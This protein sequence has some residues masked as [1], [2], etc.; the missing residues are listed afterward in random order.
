MAHTETEQTGSSAPEDPTSAVRRK[1]RVRKCAIIAAVLAGGLLVG[2]Y[3]VDTYLW[4]RAERVK[5]YE[6]GP[7]AKPERCL[8][9]WNDN[10]SNFLLFRPDPSLSWSLRPGARVRL[11]YLTQDGRRIPFDVVVNNCGMR[12]RA[13]SVRKS[14]GTLRVFC[15]GDSRTF[16]LGVQ[17]DETY[18]AR[19]GALASEELPGRRAESFNAGVP[20]YT[21][22]QGLLRIRQLLRFR[23]DV[24]T[25]C[26]STNDGTSRLV[27]DQTVYERTSHW[28]VGIGQFLDRSMLY[29]QL[30]QGVLRRFPR[31]R[32][33]LQSPLVPR[34]SPMEYVDNL[35]QLYALC[36]HASIV[37]IAVH[38]PPWS[39][40]RFVMDAYGQV[41]LR[42]AEREGMP[43]ADFGEIAC[44]SGAPIQRLYMNEGYLNGAG[45]ALLAKRLAGLIAAAE[46][47]R[48]DVP[49]RPGGIE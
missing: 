27:S 7:A 41:A 37:P 1:A 23:P 16:G 35:R 31:R 12:G 4:R 46:A 20:G 36:R 34:V 15:L 3:G 18:A 40:G 28:R 30:R 2:L 45:H 29:L 13:P 5:V 25:F 33:A 14:T 9:D 17:D 47:K 19:V 21:S 38:I 32:P 24:I 11:A 44:E 49:G 22:F 43:A 10:L 39:E 48:R 8:Y 6:M 42:V 26:F